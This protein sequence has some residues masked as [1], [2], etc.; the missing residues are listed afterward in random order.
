VRV[1]VRRGLSDLEPDSL[2]LVACSGGPDSMALAAACAFAAPRLGLRVGLST[3]DHG[4]QDGSADRAA[5]L[6]D[7]ARAGGLDPVDIAAVDVDVTDGGPESAARTARYAALDRLRRKHNAAAVL[8]A[9]ARGSGPR[10][11]AAMPARRGKLRRPLLRVRRTDT[12]DSCTELSLP[13]WDDPHNADPAYLRSRLRASLGDLTAALGERLIPNLARTATLI[14]DDLAALDRYAAQTLAA[15][16]V[17]TSL[18]R[19]DRDIEDTPDL[20]AP[21]HHAAAGGV[22]PSLRLGELSS[23]PRAVRTRALRSWVI[24][25][26]ADA[27]D[28]FFVHIEA[29]DALVTAW[30]GQKAVQLPG[31]VEVRRERDRL[32]LTPTR[33]QEAPE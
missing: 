14:T 8:L 33:R 6:A 20:T 25:E 31:G 29:L 32:W 9:L 19:G 15:A 1:A 27:D 23:V 18:G 4:L 5:A 11:I 30:R 12:R 7:W 13:V 26:G 21:S 2:L 28:L 24:E 22:P 3:I 10:G 17:T 16:R